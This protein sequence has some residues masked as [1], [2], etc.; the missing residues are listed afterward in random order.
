MTSTALT[1]AH[2]NAIVASC[3]PRSMS[4]PQK[5]NCTVQR[6]HPLG[7]ARQAKASEVRMTS[8]IQEIVFIVYAVL[9]LA[10][11]YEIVRIGM[12]ERG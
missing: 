11:L 9:A 5:S 12:A 8:A 6:R 7:S 4:L 10:A 3:G 1:V 2:L